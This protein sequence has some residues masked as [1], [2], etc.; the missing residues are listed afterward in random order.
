MKPRRF[1]ISAR[2]FWGFRCIVDLEEATTEASILDEIYKSLIAFLKEA[3]LLALLDEVT[4]M[5]LHLHDDVTYMLSND[6]KTFFACDHE[7]SNV[8]MR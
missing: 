6:E 5:N 7:C 1:Q 3:N 8:T 2:L 4:K